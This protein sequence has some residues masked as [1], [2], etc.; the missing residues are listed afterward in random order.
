MLSEEAYRLAQ[1]K[2]ETY[3]D[4]A[5]II[6]IPDEEKRIEIAGFNLS[7][8]HVMGLEVLVYVNTERV[9][10]KEIVMFPFQTCP[11]H[12]HPTTEKGPGKEET[13]RC[14]YGTVHLYVPGKPSKA[15]KNR[16][17]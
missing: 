13:F 8:L 16:R 11:E 1:A 6:I 12:R 2:A 4:R 5:G 3:F 10:A 7:D 14:R 15:P 9:C 17:P